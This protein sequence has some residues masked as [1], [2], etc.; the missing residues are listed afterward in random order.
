MQKRRILYTGGSGPGEIES[1][2]FARRLRGGG[3]NSRRGGRRSEGRN[4]KSGCGC[5]SAIAVSL[6][7]LPAAAA[8]LITK[9]EDLLF[10]NGSPQPHNSPTTGKQRH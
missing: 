10:D 8:W 5:C 3:L 6:L 2:L 7:A 1:S 4:K 9:M